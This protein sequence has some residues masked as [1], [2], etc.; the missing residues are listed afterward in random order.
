MVFDKWNRER[1]QLRIV[2][3]VVGYTHNDGVETVG[4]STRKSIFVKNVPR[5][6]VTEQQRQL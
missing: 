3:T 1:G 4:E 5:L 6:Q 2:K